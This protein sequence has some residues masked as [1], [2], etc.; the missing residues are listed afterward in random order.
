MKDD[1]KKERVAEWTR[2][3]IGERIPKSQLR[4]ELGVQRL[5]IDNLITEAKQATITQK[6]IDEYR[7]IQRQDE[8]DEL[9]LTSITPQEIAN[10]KRL[11]YQ[12]GI[13]KHSTSKDRELCGKMLGVLIEKSKTEITHKI[14]GS[15]LAREILEAKRE[16]RDAG[17]VEVPD[18]PRILPAE[19]RL[20][21]GQKQN[22]NNPI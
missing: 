19:L 7:G 13:D 17:M 6:A 21:S 16:L 1:W 12:I 11:L 10:F 5:T 4:K 20:P 15:Y 22:G 18:E 2:T 3:P 9:N 14:D 8:T